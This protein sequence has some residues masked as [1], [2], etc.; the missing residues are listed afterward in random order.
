MLTAFR[1]IKKRTLAHSTGRRRRK[2]VRSKRDWKDVRRRQFQREYGRVLETRF[3]CHRC[4]GP[5]SE[6]MQHCPWC[7]TGRKR[8]RDETRFPAHCPRCKRG[9][10]LDWKYCP[11]CYGRGLN[12][13]ADREYSDRRYEARC[14]NPGCTRKSLMPFMRYCSWCNRSVK[15]K[16]PVPGSKDR[17]P[18]CKWGVVSAFWSTCP[19]C[20]RKL[21]KA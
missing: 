7:G 9:V 14:A 21:A 1:R 13:R 8:H 17:C 18:S 4:G 6:P 19:W 12:N 2:K 11:W 3:E 10:K 15:R 20:G 5:V 16:W